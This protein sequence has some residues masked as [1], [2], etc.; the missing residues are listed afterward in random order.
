MATGRSVS[1]KLQIGL[2]QAKRRTSNVASAATS[3][4][5]RRHG[6]GDDGLVGGCALAGVVRQGAA[7]FAGSSDEAVD[8]K[9]VSRVHKA[10]EKVL[11]ERTAHAGRL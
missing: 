7:G 8:L 11:L 10:G 1:R 6:C 2:L 9:Q 5:A 4:Q 3:F